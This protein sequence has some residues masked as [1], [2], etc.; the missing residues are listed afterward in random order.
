MKGEVAEG[1]TS[2]PPGN[3]RSPIGTGLVLDR[4]NNMQERR[5]SLLAVL[6]EAYTENAHMN[7][8]VPKSRKWCF[9]LTDKSGATKVANGVSR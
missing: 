1:V 8:V 5:Q 9:S 7:V 6:N 4:M 3:L 2:S